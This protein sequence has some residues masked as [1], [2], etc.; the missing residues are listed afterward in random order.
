MSENKITRVTDCGHP[1]RSRS[2]K[3]E[4]RRRDGL[5]R[6]VLQ[7][8]EMQRC[9]TDVLSVGDGRHQR[10]CERGRRRSAWEEVRSERSAIQEVRFA[11]LQAP[12]PINSRAGHVSQHVLPTV[13]VCVGHLI[14]LYQRCV[15]LNFTRFLG[16]S[17][18]ILPR[19]VKRGALFL[20]TANFN[21]LKFA[22]MPAFAARN[23]P[24]RNAVKQ[25]VI[26][27]Y[28]VQT[29]TRVSIFNT[30]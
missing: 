27:S 12:A 1:H 6:R 24:R 22:G 4:E 14:K 3:P 20:G 10:R 25:V 17:P 2:H 15:A 9:S 11:S 16:S 30:M 23:S 26:I 8:Y 28:S 29:R 18:A 19:L 13:I 5:R 21:F 7:V